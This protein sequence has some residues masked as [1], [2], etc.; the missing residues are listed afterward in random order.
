[1][2]GDSTTAQPAA[3]THVVNWQLTTRLGE[4]NS[5]TL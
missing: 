3:R 5:H 2:Q 1:M 4:L